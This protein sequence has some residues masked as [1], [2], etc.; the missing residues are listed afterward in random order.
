M[1]PKLICFDFDGTLTTENSWYKLNTAMG[2]LPE[3]DYHLFSKYV[4]G[5]ITYSEWLNLIETQYRDNGLAT[6]EVISETLEGLF[7]KTDAEYTI[8]ELQ[9]RNYKIIIISGGFDIAIMSAARRLH[10]QNWVAGT[11]I[12]FDNTGKFTHFTTQ[13]DEANSKLSQLTKI[14]TKEKISLND[15]VCI[16]DGGNMIKLFE[17]TGNGIC[18]AN[19]TDE[20]KSFAKHQIE[21]L[22]DLLHIFK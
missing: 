5:E 18:F 9:K 16:G 11:Y 14:C 13:G 15:C 19:G 6:I 7:L 3:Q 22:S 20:V 2:I 17:K 12:N 8:S 1:K 10:V 21:S 4:K